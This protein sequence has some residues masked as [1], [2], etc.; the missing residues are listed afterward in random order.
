MT[1]GQTVRLPKYAYVGCFS[2]GKSSGHGEGISVY[3]IAPS[4]GTWQLVEI[5]KSLPSPGFL[6]LDRQG[7][8]LYAGHGNGSEISAY[9][10]DPASGKL[11]LLNRQ[12]T[13]GNNGLHLDVHPN[14][15]FLALANGPV[16]TIFPINPDGTLAPYI[17][18]NKFDSAAHHMVLFDATGRYL[19][20]TDHGS[21][22]IHVFPF[23]A[24]SGKLVKN[25]HFDV[26][27]PDAGPRHLAFHPSKPW[28]Y[29]VNKNSTVAAYQWDAQNGQLKPFQVV[30]TAPD[31]YTGPNGA[32]EI[33]IA[34]TGNFAYVANRPHDTIA[35]F[36][37]DQ[38]KGTLKAIAW[39]PIQGKHPRFFTL[40]AGGNFLYS[41]ALE[42]DRIVIFSIN[43]DTGQLTPT[44][45]IVET[46]SPTCIAFAYQ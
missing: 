40:D 19:L 12:P 38:D 36:A 34:P 42:S 20:A 7:K 21:H 18:S 13:G 44:G 28:V 16:I 29:D 15:R 1:A 11:K 41:A 9:V 23:D 46:P 35:T 30:R 39:E 43:S 31:S 24:T 6:V 27:R 45:Q 32:S 33:A 26:E 5:V 25:R 2:P 4:T 3:R 8:Y 17:D 22:K 37:I 10:I 14:N